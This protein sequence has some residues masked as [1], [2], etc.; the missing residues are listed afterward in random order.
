[1]NATK[2]LWDIMLLFR[3]KFNQE[4]YTLQSDILVGTFVLVVYH[5]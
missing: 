2:N 3:F 1:M 5:L 4:N